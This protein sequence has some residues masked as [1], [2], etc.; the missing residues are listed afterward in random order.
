MFDDDFFSRIDDHHAQRRAEFDKLAADPPARSAEVGD[1][2]LLAC[3]AIGRGFEWERV[4]G[5][6][7]E[8]AD[9]AYRVKFK[10]DYDKDYHDLWVHRFIVTD[11]LGPPTTI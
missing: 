6:V 4:E 8:V 7:Q 1:R 10:K 2:V 5:I 3:G 9:T 11:V